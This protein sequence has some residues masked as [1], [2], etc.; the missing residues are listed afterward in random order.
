MSRR[1][2]QARTRA[3][4]GRARSY[5][6][7]R[8][9]PASPPADSWISDC[10]TCSAVRGASARLRD[11]GIS[12]RAETRDAAL[13]DVARLQEAGL[14]GVFDQ[15]RDTED[16]VRRALV[17]HG[18]AVQFQDDLQLLRIRNEG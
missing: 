10:S 2:P 17:L 3:A 12:L 11:A 14:R 4:A 7:K 8:G 15:P 13:E 16:H 1:A 6:S 5:G 9:R 18:L